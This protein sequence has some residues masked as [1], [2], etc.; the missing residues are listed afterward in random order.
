MH[1]IDE[2]IKFNLDKIILMPC[3]FDTHR[4][5]REAKTLENKDKW[6]SLQAVHNNEVYA[7][8]AGA[9]FSKPGPST[10]TVLVSYWRSY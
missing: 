9:Y 7:V 2:I 6:K 3:G 5:L 1:D 8:K 4:T 10:I